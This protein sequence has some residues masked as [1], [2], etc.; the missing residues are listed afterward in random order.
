MTLKTNRCEGPDGTTVSIANSD[1]FGD[2]AF[3]LVN[4]TA[5][6]ICAYE[7]TNAWHDTS[8]IQVQSTTAAN[9]VQVGWTDTAATSF[10][11]RW[12]ERW[13]TIPSAL[14]QNG[15]NVRGSAGATTLARREMNTDGTFRIVM[16][17]A[18]G[19]STTVL[20]TG[21]WYR[22]E[23]EGTAFNSSAGTLTCR[24]YT[25]DGTTALETLNL[26]AHDELV[27]DLAANIGSSTPI[28]P[29]LTIS[30]GWTPG[31]DVKFG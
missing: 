22:F 29:A 14:Q 4:I 10:S 24:V 18:S 26:T 28:G 12:Y 9:T 17:A 25:G 13:T 16:A 21:T 15:F 30:P 8:A 31:Y 11:C 7:T 1:D 5:G 20:S 2:T 6:T 19:N 23:V 27:D 3:D